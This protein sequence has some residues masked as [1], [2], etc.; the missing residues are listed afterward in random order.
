MRPGDAGRV[1]RFGGGRVSGR[2]VRRPSSS[3]LRGPGDPERLRPT[4]RGR[5][6]V[7]PARR[8][9]WFFAASGGGQRGAASARGVLPCDRFPAVGRERGMTRGFGED[10]G[11]PVCTAR[12]PEAE[13]RAGLIPRAIHLRMAGG[14]FPKRVRPG[15]RVLGRVEA[16]WMCGSGA[17]CP[18]RPD[19]ELGS[20]GRGLP[21]VAS[22]RGPL[23]PGPRDTDGSG[24]GGSGDRRPPQ[25]RD[26]AVSSVRPPGRRVVGCRMLRPR[27]RGPGAGA[28]PGGR[29]RDAA[30]GGGDD[31]HRSG[32][33]HDPHIRLP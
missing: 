15:A 4:R 22:F 2:T 26:G 28:H 19:R 23:P 25:L 24:A 14:S 5:S 1:V 20:C 9:P 17:V 12:S 3:S 10:A 11:P 33:R 30:P 21:S 31:R 32:R 8:M 18:R 6:P 29:G 13:S 7:R 27:T 16:E